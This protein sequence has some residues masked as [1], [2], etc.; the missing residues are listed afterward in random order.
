MSKNLSIQ[1]GIED[2]D[3]FVKAPEE[4]NSQRFYGTNPVPVL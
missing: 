3:D 4:D 1:I 2:D